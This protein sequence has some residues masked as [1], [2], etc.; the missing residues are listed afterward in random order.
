MTT[1]DRDF[2]LTPSRRIGQ[3]FDAG[4]RAT[5][6]RATLLGQPGP[7]ALPRLA[8]A[9]GR[10]H[11]NAVRR[12]RLKRLCREAFRQVRGQMPAGWDMVI[13][14]RPGRQQTVDG[15]AESLLR[16]SGRL[17]KR[18]PKADKPSEPAE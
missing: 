15:L 1:P 5:D 16:L 7:G 4:L 6:E 10:R 17:A 11:G 14:P 12:N 9:V 13:V 8:I 3:L 18:V 2:R